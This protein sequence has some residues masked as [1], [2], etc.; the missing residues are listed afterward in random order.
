MATAAKPIS[1]G[2]GILDLLQ[3]TVPLQEQAVA[4]CRRLLAVNELSR[5]INAAGSVKDLRLVLA[6]YFQKHFPEDP[7]R[8]C[9][10]NGAHFR[11]VHLAGP[12]IPN[13]EGLISLENGI[14]GTVIRTST[15]LWIPDT[16]ESRKMRKLPGAAAATVARSILAV[17]LSAKQK[18]IGCLEMMSNQ[19]NRFDELEY[20]LGLLVAAHLS[21]SLENILTRQE[22]ARANA[23]L[24]D[25]EL[26]LTQLNLDLQ[27]MAH[28]DE[29]TGL[30]NKRRLLEQLE[31]EVARSRRYGE[32]WSF[33]MLDIDH[34][35]GIN[36]AHGHQA[37]DELLRQ[38]GTLLRRSLRITDFVARYGGEEF[39]IILPRTDNA[40]A[41]RVAENLR[42]KFMQ[43]TFELPGA[44][45]H[46][47]ISIGAACFSPVNSLNAC[48]I[49]L[50]ADNALYRAKRNGKNQACFADEIT[51]HCEDAQSVPPNSAVPATNP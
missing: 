14:A 18:T 11:R 9:I 30:F 48:Q 45:T 37:G 46:L 49:I 7:A 21:S 42:S 5:S 13:N 34:F 40:G 1:S 32:V 36:D 44:S 35:K 8:L 19:P 26:R 17:P 16:R 43:H 15:S 3:Q 39:A 41:A 27:E 28:T 31:M 23:R 4:F 47:T 33:L 2:K 51:I 6:S 29:S 22:L 38:T 10:S 24:R 25:H 12:R 20:H 50:K